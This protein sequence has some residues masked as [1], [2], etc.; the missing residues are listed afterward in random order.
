[1]SRRL[2]CIWALRHACSLE[3]EGCSSPKWLRAL[4]VVYRA[5]IC[6]FRY[7]YIQEYT[8]IYIYVYLYTRPLCGNHLCT[9]VGDRQS[10]SGGPLS[11]ECLIGSNTPETY[12]AYSA[13]AHIDPFDTCLAM[14]SE[15]SPQYETC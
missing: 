6:I 1:M 14:R 2:L 12:S 4:V 3:R 7:N 10:P 15:L 9:H 8:Y 5:T 13:V 11:T